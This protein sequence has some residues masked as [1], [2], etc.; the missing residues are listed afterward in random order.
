MPSEQ[1]S[2]QDTP[3]SVTPNAM[4]Q[5]LPSGPQA[6]TDPNSPSLT[7]AETA[8]SAKTEPKQPVEA[9]PKGDAITADERTELEKLRAIHADEK[10]WEKRAKENFDAR[11]QLDNLV[12]ALGG[13]DGTPDAAPDPL[14]E[15]AK[16]RA[17][18]A[19][20]DTEA[21][22]E[23]IARETG[24]PPSQVTGADAEAMQASANSALEWAK[25]FAAAAG[26]P[27]AAPASSVTSNQATH[28]NGVKQLSKSD[29]QGMSSA[30]IMEAYRNGQLSGIGAAPS[31]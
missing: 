17:E 6:V 28:D 31:K 1:D 24:V 2:R 3:I 27:N 25:Q 29:L 21:T 14:A 16:L 8:S 26:R 11:K 30:Q 12:K 23:R 9:A 15:I 4:P 20:K 10:K 5:T 7:V 19:S 22:R 13:G 18:L